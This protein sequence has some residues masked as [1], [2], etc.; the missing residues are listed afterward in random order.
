MMLSSQMEQG[1]FVS[2]LLLIVAT[3]LLVSCG[4]YRTDANQDW[5]DSDSIA[6]IQKDSLEALLDSTMPRGADELFNDFFFNFA[7]NKRLQKQRILIDDSKHWSYNT[8]FMEQ[9][10]YTP[11]FDDVLQMDLQND[12]TVTKAIVEK[13]FLKFNSI[14]QYTFHKLKGY[15]M[16]TSVDTMKVEQSPNGDFL[17]FYFRFA[18]DQ[19]FQMASL[20]E[21]V[22]FVGPDPDDDFDT[23]EGEILPETWPAFCPNLP[24]D[25]IY[26]IIYDD[27]N[28][29]GINSK[30]F[31]ING[32]ANGLEIRMYFSKIGKDWK[33]TK[34]EQ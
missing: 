16:L 8:F 34:F 28:G 24:K 11:I 2:F 15:W 20:T 23:L 6:T 10:Y 18:N 32:I 3:T 33:L 5:I 21:H 4:G 26:N 14:K 27:K 31:V 7:G 30:I 12:T 13:I 22:K 29:K 25:I 19:K 17:K 9:G 1:R